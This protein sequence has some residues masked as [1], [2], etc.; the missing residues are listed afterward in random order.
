MPPTTALMA[1]KEDLSLEQEA[2]PL[3]GKP[4]HSYKWRWLYVERKMINIF[5][6]YMEGGDCMLYDGTGYWFI[7][8][9][10]VIY[11]TKN[12]DKIDYQV[13]LNVFPLTVR[14]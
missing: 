12:K 7:D 11:K 2:I 6:Y 10:K 9:G 5:G 8:E 4:N 14:F 1:L 3:Y 13:G